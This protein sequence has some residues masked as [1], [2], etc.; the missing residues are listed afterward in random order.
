MRCKP[1]LATRQ[2]L[3]AHIHPLRRSPGGCSCTWPATAPFQAPHIHHRECSQRVLVPVAEGH[4]HTHT[5]LTCAHAH[6]HALHCCQVC[7]VI[8]LCTH[9]PPSC[10]LQLLEALN[11]LKRGADASEED[12]EEV[13][14]LASA[15]E[16]LN[17]QSKT[18]NPAVLSGK[19]RL[20]Y[21]TSASI[22]GLNR[23]PPF[24]P[25][26]DIFQTIGG[27]AWASSSSVRAWTSSVCSSQLLCNCA[28]F[29]LPC[30]AAAC[31]GQLIAKPLALVHLQSIVLT[32]KI[33]RTTVHPTR[34]YDPTCSTPLL[35]SA[36][37]P[38][39]LRSCGH[40]TKSLHPSSTQFLLTSHPPAALR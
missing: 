24:R 1:L 14:R 15:L 38:Q 26:G 6:T 9:T 12:K 34:E 27:H 28:V 36:L 30:M 23:P 11:G 8:V 5:H 17:P 18:L 13:D 22:L 31:P 21:T 20:L 3:L 32:A 16:K 33:L 35:A 40:A 2:G 25:L 37:L 29:H 7:A 4:T 39:T 19:W 10:C